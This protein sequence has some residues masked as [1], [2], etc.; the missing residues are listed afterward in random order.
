MHINHQEKQLK[1]EKKIIGF[2]LKQILTHQ[3]A[4][5]D[6][7]YKADEKVNFAF[8]L[9]FATNAGDR[10]IRVGTR[11]RFEQK[12]IPFILLESS[13]SFQIKEEDWK[14]LLL[15]NE[16]SKIALPKDFA[17][18]LAILSVGTARG[19]LHAKTEQ[20]DFNK[21]F[22]QTIDLTKLIKEDAIIEI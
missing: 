18:H 21:F 12:Q 19:I 8:E 17:T 7:A 6:D 10:M 14:E 2:T 9:N 15:E 13:C 20:T 5:V 11:L 3:F 1:M 4:I 16:C 22:I